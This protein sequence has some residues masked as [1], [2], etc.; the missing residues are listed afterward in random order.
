MNSTASDAMDN[1]KYWKLL[2][3]SRQPP[4]YTRFKFSTEVKCAHM[5][6]HKQCPYQTPQIHRT[7]TLC[8]AEFR[9]CPEV[10]MLCGPL[11]A[12][13]NTFYSKCME[14]QL[15]SQLLFPQSTYLYVH[16][17]CGSLRAIHKHKNAFN[18]QKISV[19][20]FKKIWRDALS[21]LGGK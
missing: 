18:P 20:L 14:L 6:A 16:L 5:H 4:V 19:S 3:L 13:S 7:F 9:Q 2:L 8:A 21:F 12:A 11:R 15:Q 1:S 17:S 10:L